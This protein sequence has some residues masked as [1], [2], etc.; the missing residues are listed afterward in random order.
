MGEQDW[1]TLVGGGGQKAD[2][3]QSCKSSGLSF[4]GLYRL[5]VEPGWRKTRKGSA[6]GDGVFQCRRERSASRV[7]LSLQSRRIG[8]VLINRGGPRLPATCKCIDSFHLDHSGGRNC[9]GV[10][11][12]SP[13]GLDGAHRSCSFIHHP[14]HLCK[15]R[16][17]EVRWRALHLPALS[18]ET[19]GLNAAVCGEA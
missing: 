18:G 16:G 15:R 7:L 5:S 11:C 8:R 14:A 1:T 2:K 10:F 4:G 3:H 6:V 13:T 17:Q 12:L 19:A 9:V